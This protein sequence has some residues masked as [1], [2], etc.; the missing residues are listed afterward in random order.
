MTNVIDIRTGLPIAN[1][2]AREAAQPASGA[3]ALQLAI[4]CTLENGTLRTHRYRDHL[5]LWDLTHAG[6]RGKKVTKLSLSPAYTLNAGHCEALMEQL[7]GVLEK[8]HSFEVA[9]AML[10]HLAST[11]KVID[12]SASED[13]GVDVAPASFKPITIRTE[14]LDLTASYSDF[15][16]CCLQDQHNQP[17]AIPA[18]KHNKKSIAQFYAWVSANQDSIKTMSYPQVLEALTA[19]GIQFHRYCRMD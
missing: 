5:V 11:S 1:V 15:S 18:I 14:I 6:K 19:Q 9:S 17:A 12:L 13:R 2:E 16:V 10:N 8:L 3:V 4:G 7:A